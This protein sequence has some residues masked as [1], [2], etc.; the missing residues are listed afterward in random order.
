MKMYRVM[1]KT[2]HVKRRRYQFSLINRLLI[3]FQNSTLFAKY[4]RYDYRF[5]NIGRDSKSTNRFSCL[6]SNLNI[7]L[8]CLL[9]MI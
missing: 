3:A 5:V 7:H 9:N 8:L 4:Y 1:E 2:R 6:E